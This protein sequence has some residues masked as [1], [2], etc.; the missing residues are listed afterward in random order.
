[1]LSDGRVLIA[2]GEALIQSQKASL[3]SAL[4]IDARDPNKVAIASDGATIAMRQARM[5]H[6]AA[7]LANGKVV[8]AGGK[9]LSTMAGMPDTFLSSIEVFDPDKGLFSLP[10]N[11]AG[12]TVELSSGRFGHSGTLLKTGY[13]VMITGGRSAT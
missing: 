6:V 11:G 12:A 7:R 9:V 13:D 8:F 1:L 2:G 3:R 10:V 5:G 4:I